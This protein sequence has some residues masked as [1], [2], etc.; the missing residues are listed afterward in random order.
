MTVDTLRWWDDK[1]MMIL[2]D[3]EGSSSGLIGALSQK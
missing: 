2:K 3:L 1:S